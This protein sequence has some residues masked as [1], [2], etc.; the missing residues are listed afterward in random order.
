MPPAQS[1]DCEV[2]C[3]A[4]ARRHAG[5][6]EVFADEEIPARRQR[7]R[8]AFEVGGNVPRDGMAASASPTYGSLGRSGSAA[9]AAWRAL[10]A[11]VSSFTRS[12]SAES[13]LVNSSGSRARS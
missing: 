13:R 2:C 10:N 12:G 5:A 8:A 7:L 1:R 9:I 4:G 11:A 6:E 3:R